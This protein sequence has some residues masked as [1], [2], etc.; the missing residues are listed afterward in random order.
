MKAEIKGSNETQ[1]RPLAIP[2]FANLDNSLRPKITAL[3]WTDAGSGQIVAW[4]TG[5]AFLH[6]TAVVL[7]DTIYGAGSAAFFK[8]GEA[9]WRLTLPAAKLAL[10]HDA[11]L[12]GEYR[13][14]TTIRPP[15]L[16]GLAAPN[17]ALPI[18]EITNT[19]VTPSGADRSEIK[20]EV[21]SSN[22]NISN[23]RLTSRWWR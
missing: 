13:T 12:I 23:P 17:P 22:G 15:A 19:S 8:Q 7:G 21:R 20:V 1:K 10:V 6:G 16:I 18:L 9:R 5:E 3:E 11:H 2:A 14:P 4:A